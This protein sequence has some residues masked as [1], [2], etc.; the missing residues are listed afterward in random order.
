MNEASSMTRRG[1]K[2]AKIL[3]KNQ[4]NVTFCKRKRGLLKKTIE[5]SVLCGQDILLVMFD[6]EKQKLYEYKSSDEFDVK[7]ARRL[8]SPE[9]RMQFHFEQYSNNSYNMFVNDK[10]ERGETVSYYDFDE[11]KKDLDK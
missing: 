1:Q 5:M 2:L 11:S 8:L 6:R 4:R 9:T 7:V 3:D 10:G